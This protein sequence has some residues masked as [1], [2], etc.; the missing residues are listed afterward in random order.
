MIAA[1]LLKEIKLLSR[2]LHGLAVLFVMPIAFML[3]MSLALSRDE[4]PQSGSRIALVG[5]A[6]DSVN[7]AFAAALQ[8]E[9]MA[10]SLMPP[11]KLKEAQQGLHEKRFQLVLHNPNQAGGKLTESLPLDI[12]V[13]PDTEP[14]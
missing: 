6:G 12:Y 10:V 9:Q 8:K 2:D 11:E 13:P 4:D 3:I 7:T 5:K 14:S 1:S